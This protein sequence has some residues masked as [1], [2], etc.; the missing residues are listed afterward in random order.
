MTAPTARSIKERVEIR[1]E[2]YKAHYKA[3][4]KHF[5]KR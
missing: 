4:T 1:M 5:V 3:G 2:D